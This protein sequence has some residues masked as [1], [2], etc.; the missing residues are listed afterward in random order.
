MERITGT[1]NK[2]SQPIIQS[3]LQINPKEYAE[4]DGTKLPIKGPFTAAITQFGT[5]TLY[6]SFP[7]EI[8]LYYSIVKKVVH[9]GELKRKLP[10][11]VY[12][13]PPGTAIKIGLGTKTWK[14]EK[15]KPAIAPQITLPDAIAEYRELLLQSVAKRLE[16]CPPGK[17]ALSCSGG[18][19]SQLIAWALL[20]LGVDFISFTA[21]TSYRSW[22]FHH[23][24]RNLAAM[25]A[26]PP[27]PVLIDKQAVDE[28]IEEGLLLFEDI[29]TTP[30]HMWQAVCHVAIARQCAALGVTSIFNGHGQ[31][32]VMGGMRGI[33]KELIALPDTIENAQIWRDERIRAFNDQQLVWDINKL[34]SSIFRHYG[35]HVRMPYYDWDFMNWVLAQRINIIPINKNKPFVKKAAMVILPRGLWSKEDYISTGY[36]KGVGFRDSAALELRDY[37]DSSARQAYNKLFL[38]ENFPASSAQ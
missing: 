36:V 32:D 10:G 21:C 15:L 8:P 7:A 31:D 27:I 18:V 5:T 28:S 17:I 24:K 16:T 19:D 26:N 35:I 14:H 37:V 2:K 23:A 25:D 13:V 6:S 34:F 38:Q 9:W 1:Y 20:Q 33:F 29:G 3:D 12:Q 30:Q 22:D 11:K 4:F